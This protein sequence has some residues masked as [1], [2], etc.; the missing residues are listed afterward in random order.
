MRRRIVIL[1]AFVAALAACADT[2]TLHTDSEDGAPGSTLLAMA[3]G[4]APP[5][6]LPPCPTSAA[7]GAIK[8]PLLAGGGPGCSDEVPVEDG[9]P[10]ATTTS[11]TG[12]DCHPA[13]SSPC[14]PNRSGDALNCID[15]PEES[16]PVVVATPGVDPYKLDVDNDG[17][18]CEGP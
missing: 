4:G 1:V 14:L 15:V 13:Y 9:I 8:L 12:Q 17:E 6:E 16:K 18:G 2:R 11:T 3:A 10:M 5:A 7:A